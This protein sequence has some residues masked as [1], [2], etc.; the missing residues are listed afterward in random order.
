MSEELYY[1]TQAQA[2]AAYI[3]QELKLRPG[4]HFRFASASS[5]P[6]VLALA[7]VINPRFAP[8]I[9]GMAEQLSMAAGLDGS[10]AVRIGRG[11]KGTLTI[12]VPKPESLCW[13]VPVSA[14]PH[15]RGLRVAL[16][17][18]NDQRPTNANFNDP[19]TPHLLIAG[20]TGS[21][22]TVAQRL[23][24]YSLI[25]QTR[26]DQMGLVLIDARKRGLCWRHFANVPHLLH[27]VVTE[28]SEALRVLA[29]AVAEIGRRAETGQRRPAVFICIDEVQALLGRPE[30]NRLVTDIAGV[31]RE[32][33]VHLVIAAQDPTAKQM[34]DSTIKG[35]MTARLVGKVNSAQSAVV[36][37]GIEETGAQ[38]LTGSGDM[39]LIAPSGV[40]RLTVGHFTG[41]DAETLPYSEERQRLDLSG[42]DDADYVHS[43]ARVPDPLEPEHVAVALGTGRGIV[44]LTRELGIGTRKAARVK[45][46]ADA[47]RTA[48]FAHGYT[49]IP[50]IPLESE[51]ET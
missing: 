25:M 29:W 5:G 26:P 13:E 16:G 40:S 17:L 14:L 28:D 1:R 24:V 12:E 48:W 51:Q 4:K 27:P 32:F 44:W 38:H 31:G 3:E 7:L 42:Y 21:G 10:H 37:A 19:L 36:A 35:N 2:V 50:P 39:L 45:Q 47:M 15:R 34:G 23:L 33:G 18:N 8:K 30:V 20:T 41:R 43:S 11:D 46:F 6:C 9:I 22:K 49:T